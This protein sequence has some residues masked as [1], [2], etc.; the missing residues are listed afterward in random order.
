MSKESR[1]FRPELTLECV[2]TPLRVVDMYYVQ[3]EPSF[4]HPDRSKRTCAFEVIGSRAWPK[5][6]N[7]E[8][9]LCACNAALMLHVQYSTAMPLISIGHFDSLHRPYP[10]TT[11]LAAPT[12]GTDR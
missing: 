7:F 6:R 8:P 3:L 1:G 4:L 2:F 5:I 10:H 11:G 9:V 12:I